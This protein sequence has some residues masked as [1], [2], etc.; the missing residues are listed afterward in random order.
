MIRFQS[1]SEFSE[2]LF[3]FRVSFSKRSWPYMAA[4]S[5]PWLIHAGQRHVRKLRARADWIRH[6]SGFYRFFSDFKFNPEIFSRQLLDLVILSFGLTELL[7]VVDDTLCPKWGRR[8]FGT[9]FFYDHVRRPRAGYVWGHDWVVMAVVTRLFGA[10]IALPFWVSLYRPKKICEKGQFSTRL[11]IVVGI[12]EK[13]RSWTPLRIDLVAD[14]AYNNGPIL[15]PLATMGISLVGRLRFDAALRADP[16]KPRAKKPGRKKLWGKTLPKLTAIARSP[17]GWSLVEALIYG[18]VVRLRIKSFD[19]WWRVARAKL[20]VVIVRDPAGDRPPCYMSSTDL[21]L[22]PVQIIERFAL[23]WPIEQL[24]SD[25]KLVMGLDTAE[26]RSRHSV[27]RHALFTFGLITFVRIWAKK[28]LS[29]A[30]PAP[31]SF[32]AQL[33]PLRR[34]LLTQTIFR[35]IPRRVLSERNARALADLAAA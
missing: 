24:F 12:L 20:R 19:A 5:L 8:I 28:K 32:A 29:T 13:V 1:T 33:A 10:P 35:S 31:T 16:P 34:D 23:R 11:Q 4:M 6:E 9:A 21:E 7:L 25:A 27:L 30:D 3:N 14:G 22:S 2:I 26:V 17:K 15:K 18:K